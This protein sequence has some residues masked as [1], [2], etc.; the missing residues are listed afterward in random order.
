MESSLA[1]FLVGRVVTYFSPARPRTLAIRRKLHLRDAE[2]AR[3]F[4]EVTR[5]GKELASLEKEAI[6]LLKQGNLSKENTRIWHTKIALL[7]EGKEVQEKLATE[8]QEPGMP[9]ALP[10]N[11]QYNELARKMAGLAWNITGSNKELK[12]NHNYIV[13]ND[14]ELERKL[15]NLARNHEGIATKLIEL[16]KKNLAGEIALSDIIWCHG[17]EAIIY[18]TASRVFEARLALC[19]TEIKIRKNQMTLFEEAARM[20]EILATM[21]E[22]P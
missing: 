8:R 20:H 14:K 12:R 10:P 11:T 16:E 22:N 13:E 17:H 3:N 19:E 2:E 6:L 7:A 5:V 21:C 9:E 4:K 15:E 18:E 1:E